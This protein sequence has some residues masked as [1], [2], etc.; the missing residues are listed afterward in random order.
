MYLRFISGRVNPK[1][2]FKTFML[3]SSTMFLIQQAQ[4]LVQPEQAPTDA[5]TI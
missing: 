3:I 4:L 5:G 1:F 2:L